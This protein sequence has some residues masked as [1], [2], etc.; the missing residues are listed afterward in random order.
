MPHRTRSYDALAGG[1][2]EHRQSL[3]T[4]LVEEAGAAVAVPIA[5]QY[6]T[7]EEQPTSGTRKLVGLGQ[8]L[9]L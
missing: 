7:Q 6:C 2:R 5:V 9:W 1:V 4:L 3:A 8:R